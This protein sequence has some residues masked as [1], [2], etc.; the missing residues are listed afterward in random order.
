MTRISWLLS[1][2]CLACLAGPV[3]LAAQQAMFP[4]PLSPRLA[5]YQIDVRLDTGRKKLFGS[6]VLQWKNSSTDNIKILQ[7]HLYLNGFKNNQSTYWQGEGGRTSSDFLK[8]ENGW[9]WINVTKIGLPD[10]TILTDSCDYV[11]PDDQNNEDQTVLQVNLPYILKPGQVITLNI[12]FE[13]QLPRVIARTG[14]EG[15][16]FMVGQWFPKIGVYEP[17]GLRG[18]IQGRWNCHQFHATSEFYADYG[19]Y[20]VTIRLPQEY[21]VAAT[22]VKIAEKAESDGTKSLTYYCED[23]HDFAWSADTD[24]QIVEDQW[25]Q[26]KLYFYGQPLH[27]AQAQRHLQ[28]AK[29]MFQ[30][31]SEWIGPYPYPVFTIVDPQYRA[32]EAAGM[33][34]PTL[35][36]AGTFWLMP[37]GLRFP[38]DVTVHEGVHNYFYGLIGSNEFEEAWLDEGMTTY[39][40]YKIM[41]QYYGQGEGTF[42]NMC[43]LDINGLEWDW[44]V[45]SA[46]SRRDIIV[47]KSWE[48]ERGGYGMLS[49]TKPALM[50]LTLE[51]YVGAAVMKNILH[52]YYDQYKFGHPCTADFIR[53]VNQVSGQD[54]NWFFDQVLY[55]SD[56]L[57]YKLD[58]ITVQSKSARQGIF[59]DS[60][61][62]GS[63]TL[64]IV[65][66]ND[67]GKTGDDMDSTQIHISK[68]IVA[69]EGEV[70]FPVEI[71]VKFDNGEEVLEK[72]DGRD[73]FVVYKYERT[74][75][76][77]S[78]E[79]DP[80]RK[81]WLDRNFMNNGKTVEIN[82][83]ARNKYILRWL[84]WMQNLLLDTSLLN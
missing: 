4:H 34:Y 64:E 63:D 18:T 76:V 29:N 14:Y 1:L 77:V 15:D 25:Q 10:G 67:S 23:V 73:R 50:L 68:V 59:A 82:R 38:E 9:G 41:E 2:G 37:Q 22:G 58:K 16:F 69:R 32:F 66:E 49:Y 71:L 36:T 81:V 5:N 13:A 56:V 57:D 39:M 26:V 60:T 3:G 65:D 20:E 19:V 74:A 17:A 54:L 6:E 83:S 53:V 11:Q 8:Q 44:P 75:A 21:I 84:F 31:C 78:A 55:G 33:E 40:V 80:Q 24:Y 12:D 52:Q 30:Y 62:T 48:Y 79:V 47:K 45:Y 46:L 42:L 27:M 51:N 61:K 70:I 7:F 28:A 72:W 43:D 35:I